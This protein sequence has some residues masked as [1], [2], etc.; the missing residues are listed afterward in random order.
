MDTPIRGR[1][2]DANGNPTVAEAEL[3]VDIKGQL[4]AL[5]QLS[6]SITT[7]QQ[8]VTNTAAKLN[9]GVATSFTNG[10]RLKNLSTSTA[11]VFYGPSGVT[12]STGDELAPGESVI[13]PVADASTVYVIAVSAGTSTVSIAG[14][15]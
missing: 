13:L 1:V 5:T 12:T 10:F 7:G 3:A 9:G 8:A 6:T 14:L 11:P 15:S 4:K 2:T